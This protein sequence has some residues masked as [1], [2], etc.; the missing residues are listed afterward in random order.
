MTH[1]LSPRLPRGRL[2]R[3]TLLLATGTV[4]VVALAACGSGSTPESSPSAA[5]PSAT[6]GSTS[7]ATQTPGPTATP[8]PTPTAAGTPVTFTCDQVLTLDDVYAFNPS[9]GTAPGFEPTIAAGQT[10]AE[11]QGLNCGLLNQSSD[12]TIEVSVTQPNDVL[13]SQLKNDAISSSQIVPTYG[14]PPAVE[15]YFS[16]AGGSGVAQVFTSTYWITVGSSEFV[17]PGDAESLVS[18]AIANLQ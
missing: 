1:S 12:G 8:T 10:A 3:T 2:L 9:Y 16:A 4:A 15:G 17:E 7:D 6:P 11:Y 14:T 18:A 5:S 13:L